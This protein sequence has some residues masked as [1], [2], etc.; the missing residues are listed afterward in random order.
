MLQNLLNNLGQLTKE[1]RRL[2]DDYNNEALSRRNWQ[3]Q[4]ND[5]RRELETI[6]H[7]AESDPFALV[8][9]D[10]DGCIFQ[11]ALLKKAGDGGAE[12]AHLLY[13]AI[14]ETLQERG[15]PIGTV[16]VNIYA[17]LDSLARKLAYVGLI[18]TPVDLQAFTRSFSMNKPLFNFV[19]VG[20]GKERADH[21][22]KGWF[23]TSCS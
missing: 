7:R 11:D 9:I 23:A 8:L 14:L 4:A 10:G 21:K 16:M 12:A 2:E 6:R 20:K 19:D 15:S 3:T 22:I 17:D 13:N 5:H 1:N 18:N